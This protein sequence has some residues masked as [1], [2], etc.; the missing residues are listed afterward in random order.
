MIIAII[1]LYILAGV[2][3]TLFFFLDKRQ[4]AMDGQ[5]T[6]KFTAL[7]EEIETIK[8]NCSTL[9]ENDEIL[10]KDIETLLHEFKKFEKKVKRDA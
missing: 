8:K 3:G 5:M 10:A 2:L 1:F 4:H 6:E 9:R 7:Q